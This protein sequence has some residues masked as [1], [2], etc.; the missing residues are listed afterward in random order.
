MLRPDGEIEH[1]Q[2]DYHSEPKGQVGVIEQA[3]LV[4]LGVERT[5]SLRLGLKS[6][7]AAMSW[8]TP[9]KITSR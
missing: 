8:N 7:I 9:T 4:L 6:S 3:K 5:L 2:R 1:K